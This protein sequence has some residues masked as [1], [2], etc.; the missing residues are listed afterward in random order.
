MSFGVLE[1][2]RKIKDE[3]TGLTIPN[4]MMEKVFDH[5]KEKGKDSFFLLV[6]KNNERAINFYHKYNA[7]TISENVDDSIIMKF[8]LKRNP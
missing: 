1:E 3:N 4:S 5:F 2:Y 8:D 7:T 6:L